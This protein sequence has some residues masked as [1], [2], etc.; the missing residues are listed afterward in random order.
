MLAAQEMDP[1]RTET[2]LNSRLNPLLKHKDTKY[3]QNVILY[4]YSYPH[5]ESRNVVVFAAYNF[6]LKSLQEAS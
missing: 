2:I 3:A 5:T 4:M 1:C 6:T